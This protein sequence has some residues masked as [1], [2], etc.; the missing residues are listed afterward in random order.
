MG[1]PVTVAATGVPPQVRARAPAP[2]ATGSVKV[3]TTFASTATLV[4]PAAGAMLATAIFRRFGVAH[5]LYFLA[6]R[7]FYTLP[8]VG[9]WLPKVGAV[10]A[11]KDVALRILARGGQFVVFPGGDRDSHKPFRDRHKVDFHGHAGRWLG[12]GDGDVG[13]AGAV[14]GHRQDRAGGQRDAQGERGERERAG[15]G[16]GGDQPLIRRG[17]R[18]GRSR[19]AASRAAWR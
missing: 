1:P 15:R 19:R 3:T 13:G 16:R 17:R 11:D 7:A 2:R 8:G 18:A 5:P 9:P 6:H 4:A 14:G 10:L 12:V